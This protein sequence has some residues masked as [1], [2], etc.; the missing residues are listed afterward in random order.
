MR[1]DRR[2]FNLSMGQVSECNFTVEIDRLHPL[3]VVAL[4]NCIVRSG[5]AYDTLYITE[6][7]N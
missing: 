3:Y 5:V 4:A 7:I 6:R 2:I 1:R